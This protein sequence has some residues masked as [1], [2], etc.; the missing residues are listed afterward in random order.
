MFRAA[1]RRFSDGHEALVGNQSVCVG[2]S[3]ST[4]S[5][6]RSG[7]RWW[8]I[9]GITSGTPTFVQQSTYA[10]SDGVWRWMGSAA[11][12]QSGDL[13]VGFSASSSSIVPGIRYAGRL[14]SD[15]ANDLPQGEATLFAGLGSQAARAAAGATTAT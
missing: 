2:G 11:M 10:P 1:Y 14:A 6:G 15:P 8:E 7:V 4:C 12:D 9:T 3:G 13:A 5:G